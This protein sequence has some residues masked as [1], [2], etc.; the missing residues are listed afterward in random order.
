MR[1]YG[2][3]GD[4]V[5]HSLSPRIHNAAYAALGLNADYQRLPIPPPL[6]AE[7]VKALPRSGFSGINVTIPHKRA[8]LELADTATAA[9]KEI[10][11]ANTLSFRHGKIAADNTDAPGM[12]AALEVDPAGMTALVLGAGGTARAAIWAL[13]NAG[14]TIHVWN[15]TARRAE[16]L[17]EEFGVRPAGDPGDVPRPEIIVNTTAVGMD[18]AATEES[19]CV[20]LRL[21]LSAL[22]DQTIIVDFVY[23][24]GGSPLTRAARS[25]GLRTV[26]GEE[27]LVRQAALS[28]EIWFERAAPLNAMRSA[29]D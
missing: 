20:D 22:E 13:K 23:R 21:I 14:A 3:A 28:F 25:R 15:R 9:A 19:A 11:A 27:L 6:F 2:V 18:H 26:E 12:L 1:R 16:L 7:T 17:A 8:A 10:G 4:P 29:L 24:A 5:S